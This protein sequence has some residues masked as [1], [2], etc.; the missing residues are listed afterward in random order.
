MKLFLCVD[1]GG[2]GCRPWIDMRHGLLLTLGD[3]MAGVLFLADRP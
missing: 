3:A 2:K 1:G